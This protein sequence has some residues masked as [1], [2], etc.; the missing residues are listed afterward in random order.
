MNDRK[1]MTLL[2][3]YYDECSEA[4]KTLN[5][6]RAV[7]RPG[8]IRVVESALLTLDNGKLQIAQASARRGR[9]RIAGGAIA[10]GILGAIFPPSILAMTAIGSVAAAAWNHFRDQG[11][12]KNLLREIGENIAPGGGAVVTIVED[13]WM[14]HLESALTGYALLQR[15]IF[16]CD[17]FAGL[18]VFEHK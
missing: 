18:D 3:A 17:S 13:E 7:D 12:E 8:G 15:F 10:G 16:D 11:F 4:Q 1:Y 2:V 9:R 6:L 14:G 5:A